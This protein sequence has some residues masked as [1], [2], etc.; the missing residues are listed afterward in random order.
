MTGININTYYIMIICRKTAS[1][2]MKLFSKSIENVFSRRI[3]E[4]QIENTDLLYKKFTKLA[5]FIKNITLKVET[6]TR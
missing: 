5:N 2:F 1:T 3:S 6:R 4:I